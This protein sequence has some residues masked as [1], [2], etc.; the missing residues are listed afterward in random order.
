MPP[1]RADGRNLPFGEVAKRFLDSLASPDAA[2]FVQF[3]SAEAMVS[4]LRSRIVDLQ[5]HGK[6]AK[7]CERVDAASRSVSPFFD[8]IGIFIQSNPEIPALL[9]GAIRMVFLVSHPRVFLGCSMGADSL[10]HYA[11]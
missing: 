3:E 6:L 5:A 9:W 4:E 8:V 11:R 2:N 10:F 1:V 7:L